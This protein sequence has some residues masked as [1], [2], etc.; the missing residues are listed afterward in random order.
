M[1]VV[2]YYLH[3]EE[4]EGLSYV[5]YFPISGSF[6]FRD[7]YCTVDMRT[8][9]QVSSSVGL[10]AR[11]VVPGSGGFGLPVIPFHLRVWGRL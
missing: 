2:I 10:T 5:P 8:P 4:G 7:E 3:C 9:L 6:I 11:D 1:A